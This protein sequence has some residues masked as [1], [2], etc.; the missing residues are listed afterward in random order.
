M[1]RCVNSVLQPVNKLNRQGIGGIRR[2]IVLAKIR[3]LFLGDLWRYFLD[4]HVERHEI[5]VWPSLGGY[6]PGG[7][8]D[9]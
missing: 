8:Q 9:I 3:F 2:K 7:C 1:R 5:S 4:A 6:S